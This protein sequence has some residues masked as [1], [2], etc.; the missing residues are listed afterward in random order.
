MYSVEG[1]YL[2]TVVK[3]KKIGINYIDRKLSQA[4]MANLAT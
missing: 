3:I 2:S 1:K 4:R